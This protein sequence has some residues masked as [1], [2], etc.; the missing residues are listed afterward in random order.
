MFL[1]HLPSWGGEQ[2]V[3]K[4]TTASKTSAHER[5]VKNRK[6]SRPARPARAWWARTGPWGRPMWLEV[7]RGI[8]EWSIIIIFFVLLAERW[9]G[10]STND[11]CVLQQYFGICS[12]YTFQSDAVYLCTGSLLCRGDGVASAWFRAWTHIWTPRVSLRF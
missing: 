10:A 3:K 4:P 7:A 11:R 9:G 1:R 8:F 2:E 6:V 12:G 5:K